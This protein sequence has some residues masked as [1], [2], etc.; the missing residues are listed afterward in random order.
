MKIVPIMG[1]PCG[2]KSTIARNLLYVD[3]G[4]VI[5]DLDVIAHALGYPAEHILHGDTHPAVQ[6]AMRARASII[7]AAREDRRLGSGSLLVVAT[8]G[9]DGLY[10]MRIDPGADVC[11]QRADQDNRDPSTHE[12]IDRW[13]DR[14]GSGS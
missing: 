10:S 14:H 3:E 6:L 12:Q 13:Y 8:D 1:P 5:V 11:H 9:I 4:D 7:K 2:G